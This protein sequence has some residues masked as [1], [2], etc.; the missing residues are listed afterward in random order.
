L[1]PEMRCRTYLGMPDGQ[2]MA[3]MRATACWWRRLPSRRWVPVA[4]ARAAETCP[5]TARGAPA[6]LHLER[7]VAIRGGM[8]GERPAARHHGLAQV[9]PTRAAARDHDA[10]P[11]G[12]CACRLTAD[13]Q[14]T[15]EIPQRGARHPT[16]W[17]LLPAVLAQLIQS[18]RSDP[19]QPD[20]LAGDLQRIAIHD[21]RRP[22]DRGKR[23][24][25]HQDQA[26]RR[27]AR[28][29]VGVRGSVP[30]ARHGVAVPIGPYEGSWRCW[31]DAT[32][33]VLSEEA[34]TSGSSAS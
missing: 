28:Q 11:C 33:A 22:G 1:P 14:T 18:G 7:C 30:P 24:P 9:D 2:L 8:V 3:H 19:E 13:V 27:G 4:T 16:A 5:A 17:V 21:A 31:R 12:R 34:E 29:A 15:D 32:L 23:A 10:I 26:G 20:A 6:R 25:A